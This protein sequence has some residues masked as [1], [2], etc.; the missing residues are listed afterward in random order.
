M[1]YIFDDEAS[2]GQAVDSVKPFCK[3]TKQMD[4][5]TEKQIVG[6]YADFSRYPGLAGKKWSR[7]CGFTFKSKNGQYFQFVFVPKLK[8]TLSRNQK[9]LSGWYCWTLMPQKEDSKKVTSIAEM[10]SRFGFD[11]NKFVYSDLF[12]KYI[13]IFKANV[14]YA[15]SHQVKDLLMSPP[16]SF[17]DYEELV[18]HINAVAD[19]IKKIDDVKQVVSPSD[20]Q[21]D[22]APDYAKGSTPKVGHAKIAYNA[23]KTYDLPNMPKASR[24][25]EQRRQ[26]IQKIA[27]KMNAASQKADTSASEEPTPSSSKDNHIKY[28][29]SLKHK[30]GGG[31]TKKSDSEIFDKYDDYDNDDFR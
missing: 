5:P 22:D 25:E 8:G 2:L 31:R 19:S 4:I 26:A 27:Q 3:L 11:I 17:D 14:N 7:L 20:A 21:P 24:E 28:D 23:D 29:P 1:T 30:F 15:L 16:E 18:R 9:A 6:D 13:P 10:K 12:D